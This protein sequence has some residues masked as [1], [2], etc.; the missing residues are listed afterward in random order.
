MNKT[1][2]LSVAL[3]GLALGTALVIW[4][5]AGHI[6]Q[7]ILKIGRLG[8]LY[9]LAWQLV[10]FI[11]LGLGWWILCPS[12]APWILVWGRL[13]REGGETCLPFSEIGGLIFGARAVMLAGVGFARAGAS[14]IADVMCEGVALAPFLLFGLVMLLTRNAG[15]LL[16]LFM[17]LGLGLLLAGGAAAFLMRRWIGR[18]MRGGAEKF[19]A[20][21]IKDAPGRADELQQAFDKLFHQ[22]LRIAGSSAVHVL[23]WC[24]GG[25]NVWIAYHLLGARP[26]IL[27]A[28]AIESILSGV[29]AIGFL[30]PAGFGVQELTY[31]GIGRLFGMP[32]HLSLAL[33]LIRRARDILIG[34]PALLVWQGLEASRLNKH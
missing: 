20:K 2:T 28:L 6:F 23:C 15:A 12:T 21:W 17:G 24:G 26:S 18:L 5:G 29:L 9:V 1:L 3:A 30:V 11:V 8:L 19:L 27:D 16:D 31:I 4:L 7:A 33:S 34:A 13:V 22:H 10:V 32:A 14:S 25:G